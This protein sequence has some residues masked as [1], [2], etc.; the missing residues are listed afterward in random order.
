[1]ATKLDLTGAVEARDRLERELGREVLAIS[2]VT[3]QGIPAL[4]GRITEELERLPAAPEVAPAAV[5]ALGV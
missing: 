3:G 5:P 2:A 1:M 4:I